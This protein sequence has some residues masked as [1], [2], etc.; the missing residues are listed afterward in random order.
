MS[1]SISEAAQGAGSIAQSIATISTVSRE[2]GDD[3]GSAR[4]AVEGAAGITSEL[5]RLVGQFRV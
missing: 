2:T 4:T 1:R 5:S 3:A